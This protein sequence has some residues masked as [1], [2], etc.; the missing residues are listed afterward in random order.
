[1]LTRS[2]RAV[3]SLA[4]VLAL[5]VS[6]LPVSAAELTRANPLGSLSGIGN[7][8]LRGV[9][10]NQEGTL[11]AGDHVRTG[12]KG[13]AKVSL[14]NGNRIELDQNTEIILIGDGK[15]A[16]LSL[17]AGHF[18]FTMSNNPL[19][20]V[21]RGVRI[22]PRAN[23]KGYVSSVGNGFA[24][25]RVASG[26][27][28]LRNTETKS[29]VVLTGGSERMINLKTQETSESLGQ[30]VSS[31]PAS[32]PSLPT[33]QQPGPKSNKA[34]WIAIAAGAG[35]AAIAIALLARGDDEP[36]VDAAL[37]SKVSSNLTNIS[38]ATTAASSAA[39]TAASVATAA[40]TSAAVSAA[41]KVVATSILASINTANQ[42][43]SS[44]VSTLSSL[45]SQAA[46]ATSTSAFQSIQSQILT[47]TIQIN[48][49]I[50]N[51]NTQ[52]AALRQLQQ[53]NTGFT[54]TIPGNVNNPTV[55]SASIP[56]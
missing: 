31:L 7:V 48:T 24:T 2:L 53:R 15:S 16:Q 12:E 5:L 38:A 35:G 54:I 50:A 18:G 42:T 44:Q 25:V 22:E 8:E 51:I 43:L 45:Q 28:M 27:V 56:D 52:L 17:S 30:M 32:L 33:S 40:S 14:I 29:S 9:R 1:M 3:L 41:D 46:S 6:A 23:S 49:T 55:A 21:I 20:I 37:K 10:T 34:K 11:F 47:L 13:Y 36:E 4:L 26:S 39:T 19:T